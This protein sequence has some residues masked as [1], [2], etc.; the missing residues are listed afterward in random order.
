MGK[1]FFRV[2][3]AISEME[4]DLIRERIVAGLEAAKRMGRVGGRP[5]KFKAETIE[6]AKGM[7]SAGKPITE[8]AKSPGM[9]RAT[10]Y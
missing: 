7:V 1:C 5:G 6:L 2:I 8:I 9:S 4:R 10:L 3:A